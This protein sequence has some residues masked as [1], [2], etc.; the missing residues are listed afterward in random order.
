MLTPAEMGFGLEDRLS[1]LDKDLAPTSD[2]TA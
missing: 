2:R 1:L